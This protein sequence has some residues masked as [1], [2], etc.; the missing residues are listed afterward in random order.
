MTISPKTSTPLQ[1]RARNLEPLQLKPF[2]IDP[3]LSPRQ[4]H[5]NSFRAHGG[6]D[7]AYD[8]LYDPLLPRSLLGTPKSV[9]K[10]NCSF[11][12][13]LSQLSVDA[14]QTP[15][16]LACGLCQRIYIDPRVLACFHSFCKE[17]LEQHAAGM[18]RVNC[19]SC[20]GRT[21]LSQ[22]GVSGLLVD[23]AL[24][25]AVKLHEKSVDGQLDP[26][27][28]DDANTKNCS[29]LEH[30]NRPLQYYCLSCNFAVCQECTLKEHPRPMHLL[31][32]IEN[33]AHSQVSSIRNLI[34]EVL[35]KHDELRTAFQQVETTQRRVNTSLN[36][37]HAKL[38]EAVNRMIQVIQDANDCLQKDL[39]AT[40]VNRQE[41]IVHISR[42]VQKMTGKISETVKFAERLLKY[43]HS[44]EVLVFKPLLEARLRGFLTFNAETEMILSGNMEIE[45]PRL[46]LSQVVQALTSL[47]L[48][49]RPD[50]W[51]HADACHSQ[52]SGALLPQHL[53]R[54]HSSQQL[55]RNNSNFNAA[56][57][58]LQ[59]KL[60]SSSVQNLTYID[61]TLRNSGL[62]ENSEER[63]GGRANA[64]GMSSYSSMLDLSSNSG[65]L[66]SQTDLN[67]RLMGVYGAT[68]ALSAARRERMIYYHKF[69]EFGI[70]QGQFTEP[71]GVAVTAQDEIVVADTNNHRIQVFD[72]D[73]NFKFMFGECG[74]RD[75]QLLYPNR[76]AVNKLT[77]EFI[78][79]ERSP[80]HQIQVFNQYGHFLR[81]FGANILQHPRGVCVDYRGRIVVVEC[82]VMRVIIFDTYGNIL[83]KFLCSR[84]LE[85]PNAVATNDKDQLFISDNRAH[86]I[87]VFNYNGQ[88]LHQI[89]GEGITNYPIG[90]GITAN[91]EI[92]VADNHNNFN[93]TVFNQNGE[94]ISAMES[95]V[96][97]A[98]CFDVCLLDGNTIVLASKDYRLYLYRFTTKKLD[99]ALDE[100]VSSL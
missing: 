73:G 71:S 20:N 36:Q 40:Y 70:Q 7:S 28:P 91:G 57:P 42:G 3:L 63:D 23:Y 51:N 14:A 94:L 11:S 47:S 39:D 52:T 81:K 96:K 59:S 78:V 29:C 26:Y 64:G 89:G 53:Q 19:P 85:F 87:K 18:S 35:V 30:R 32:L 4:V 21:Q 5:L 45:Q 67:A 82:K 56:L 95:R 54:T 8:S 65:A 10:P 88:F 22:L 9:D 41:Q 33:A 100:S 31:E 17:C 69:G 61:N 98:Q 49:V 55:G 34:D 25:N 76:V 60:T 92:V 99:R 86:C 62:M 6:D 66:A 50:S 15:P 44:T 12:S 48:S 74:K 2:C 38:R 84:Y 46:E 16:E 93:L 77:G 13:Q 83:H 75:G 43:G 27:E 80:T 68:K 97:H 1:Q 72:R 90:M 79:T 58:I 37:A 24:N